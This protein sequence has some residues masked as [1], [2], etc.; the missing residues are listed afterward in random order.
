VALII[1]GP[2]PSTRVVTMKLDNIVGDRGQDW[3]LLTSGAFL[4][5]AVP[6]IVFFGLQRYFVRGPLAGSAEG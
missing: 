1:L 4:S 5:K 6:L 3:H 2:D